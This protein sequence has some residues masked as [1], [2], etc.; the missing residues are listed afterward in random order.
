MK[1]YKT[2]Y[3]AAVAI[4]ML[5]LLF[6]IF[7]YAAY[8]NAQFKNTSDQ[9][10]KANKVITK[11]VQIVDDV[12]SIVL[13]Q[14]AY[15]LTQDE[16]FL[17]GYNKLKEN[18]SENITRLFEIIETDEAQI[19]RLK[20]FQ[21][22]Y[23]ALTRRLENQRSAIS[24]GEKKTS[25]LELNLDA[26][27]NRTL[28]AI[29]AAENEML[30]VRIENLASLQNKLLAAVITGILL[31]GFL[32]GSLNY[33]LYKLRHENLLIGDTLTNTEE[34][35]KFALDAS[36]EGVYDWNIKTGHIFYSK[37]YCNML[38]YE[39][40]EITP[41]L[42][43]IQALMHDEDRMTVMDTAEQFLDN[44]LS[45]FSMQFRMYHK[46]GHI[47][48]VSSRGI[49]VRDD[50]GTA[51]R[52]I[53]TNRDITDYKLTENKM[54][55]AVIDAQKSALAKGEFLAHMSHEIRTPLTA[56][57][58]ISEI[59]SKYSDEFSDRQAQ[60]IKTLSTST[61]SL[62]DLIND[63]LDFSKIERGEI[64][65]QHDFFLMSELA[66]QVISII[67]VSAN[68]KG[69]DFKVNYDDVRKLIYFGDKAR[70]R[71]VLLN[72]VGNAVK[73]TK[74]GSVYVDFKMIDIDQET[75]TL[76]IHIKDTGVGLKKDA[77]ETIFKE[78][79]QADSTVSRE[80]GGTGLGLP[81]SKRLIEMMGGDI[82]VESQI[83]EGS[84]FTVILPIADHKIISNVNDEGL[85]QKLTNRLRSAIKDEQRALIVE[86]YEGNIVILSF[87]M[88]E[89]DL[90]YDIAKNGQEALDL[91]REKHYDVILMDVQMPVMDGLTATKSIRDM[92]LKNKLPE[93]PIIGMT[94][95]ALVED[96]EKCIDSGMTD[97]LSKPLDSDL[98]KE[99]I[100]KYIQAVKIKTV[101]SK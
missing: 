74:Q 33:Y 66:E 61:T 91:W 27:L 5:C 37:I 58:G 36:Q 68:E 3:F 1:F 55:M 2:K 17:S 69:L 75:P 38:G 70:M 50:A 48:W 65:L 32:I 93:T 44:K 26:D 42:D 76:M 29:L 87:M 7:G 34:R 67:G 41:N 13:Q 23:L 47:I 72:L 35:L 77:F 63:I 79:K 12:K 94:A 59:L 46:N 40:Y 20:E 14:E 53:G 101:Q 81:I 45:E 24:E 56:I 73:F 9:I 95:H 30:E 8:N 89:I 28:N 97:Y 64:D 51:I 80:Y 6:S 15:I 54:E 99:K 88:D 78:F 31:T 22:S 11:T 25:D 39:P 96:K 57:S 98:L 82:T 71:Q 62:K 16:S 49:A 100:F 18:V 52:M 90:N 85:K 19:S 43:A 92:E 60:L 10:Y 4:M 83:G 86:D 21:N 84:E